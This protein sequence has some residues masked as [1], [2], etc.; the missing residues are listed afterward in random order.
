[1]EQNLTN[2]QKVNRIIPDTY[3]HITY[4]VKHPLI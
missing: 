1:M 2:P 3:M 4:E